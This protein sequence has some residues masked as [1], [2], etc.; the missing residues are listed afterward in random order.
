VTAAANA[1]VKQRLLL[2]DGVQAYINA[3]QAP[4]QVINNPVYGNYTW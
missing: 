3:A 4:I 2:S 1:L